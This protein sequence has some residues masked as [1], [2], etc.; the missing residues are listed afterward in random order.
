FNVSRFDAYGTGQGEPLPNITAVKIY[1][2]TNAADKEQGGTLVASGL[3]RTF[4]I[5]QQDNQRQYRFE[6][7]IENDGTV[8]WTLA[9]EDELY[10]QGLNNTWDVGKIWYNLSGQKIGGDFTGNTVSWNTSKGGVLRNQDSNDTMWAKYLVNISE[11][12]S[13]EYNQYFEVNDTSDNAGSYDHHRLNITKYGF[14]AVTLKEPPNDTTLQQNVTFK[15]NATVTCSQGICG[16]VNLSARYN[17]SSTAD[18]L[19]PEGAGTPFYT[20]RTNT[21]SCGTSMNAG[22]TCFQTWEVNATGPL[23]SV[24]LLDAN[25]SSS[26]SQVPNNDSEDSRVTINQGILMSIYWDKVDFGVLDPGQENQSAVGNDAWKYNITIEENSLDVDELWVKADD[27]VASG[28]NN[29]ATGQPYTIV[30]GNVSYSHQNDIS[31]ET[32]LRNSYQQMATTVSAGTNYSTFYWM[33]VPEGLK[34]ANY[35]GKIYF[36]ANA[37]R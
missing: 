15:M 1:D 37:T 26:L 16:D 3:N 29:P 8:D 35:T 2:V 32:E 5:E 31:T 33:D 12:S 4:L 27:L 30:A 9:G 24:H 21:N 11:T 34:T 6:F 10:H 28:W 36:K 19:I 25:A 13:Q 14:L 7:V 22:E 20:N 18:T 17:Q 23:T